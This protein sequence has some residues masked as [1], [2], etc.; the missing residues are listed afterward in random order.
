[1]TQQVILLAAPHPFVEGFGKNCLIA[2]KIVAANVNERA[3]R[4]TDM[5]DA[6]LLENSPLMAYLPPGRYASIHQSYS[7]PFPKGFT[8]EPEE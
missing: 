7:F 3:M 8:R 2:G 6:E 1:M 5:D 4:M